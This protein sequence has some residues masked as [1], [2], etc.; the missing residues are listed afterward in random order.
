MNRKYILLILSAM[1]VGAAFGAGYARFFGPI[2][3]QQ[4]AAS[5]ESAASLETTLIRP[6]DTAVDRVTAAG[7]IE[8]VDTKQVVAQVNG[9]VAEVLVEVG[10]VQ[11]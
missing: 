4:T 5:T 2:A 10:D 3:P 6:A 1:V 8:L 11:R 9:Y 7:N